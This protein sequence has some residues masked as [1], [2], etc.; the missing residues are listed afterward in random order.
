MKRHKIR[1]L[2]LITAFLLFP[3]T[4]WYISPYIIIQ[5]AM[6]RVINGSF[7]TFSMMLFC[8]IFFGRFF[9]GYLCPAGG[10]QECAMLVNEKSLKQGWKNN[11]KYGIWCIWIV[12]VVVCF[13]LSKNNVTIN[14]FYMTDHG[15][16][17]SNIYCYII[18][19]C[20]LLLIFIPAVLF[21]KRIFC[22]YFCWMAPFMIIGTKIGE[23][24]NLP[25]L[26]IK[27][28]KDKCISCKQC[29]RKCPMS[30]DVERMASKGECSNVECIL[31]GE[32]VDT[33]P[34]K[35]L[36]YS[37]ENRGKNDGKREENKSGDFGAVKP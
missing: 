22:H 17:V 25:Q 21:G 34:K 15:I 33:C 10:L 16:S 29:N 30:L 35:V 19:Y 24:L 14:P 12:A 2:L 27:A 6:E 28:E 20:V 32:C 26:H 31:C 9:C 7:I 36:R 1:K 23:L 3:I 4:M 8:S 18:Y 13:I 37:M 11:I 5:G